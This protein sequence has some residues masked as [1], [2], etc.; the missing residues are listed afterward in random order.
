[1]A[2]PAR[3]VEPPTSADMDVFESEFARLPSDFVSFLETYGTGAV[4]NFIWIFNPASKN[5][6]LNLLKQAKVQL[7]TFREIRAQEKGQVPYP[8][9]PE[10]GGLLPFGITDNGDVLF[11]KTSA[12]PQQWTIVIADSRAPEY[13]EHQLALTDFLLKLLDGELSSGIFP[14]DMPSENPMFEPAPNL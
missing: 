12:D 8:L 9:F 1:M 5:P 7:N 13:E 6:N 11:W 14:D 10:E 4:D 3:P 2:P